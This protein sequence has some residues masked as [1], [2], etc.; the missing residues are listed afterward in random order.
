MIDRYS[1]GAMALSVLL[2]TSAAQAFDDAKYPD[3]K[4]KWHRAVFR[5]LSASNIAVAVIDPF[6]ARMFAKAQ[7]IAAKTDR[8]D[9]RVLAM[10]AAMMSPQCR[11]PA[12]ER[13]EALQEFVTARASA[14]DEKTALKNQLAAATQSFLKS[15]LRKRIKQLEAHDSVRNAQNSLGPQATVEDLVRA[16]LKKGGG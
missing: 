3:L 15:Q 14:V 5:S 1:L 7:G 4:G 11:P 2:M 8:L 9:A 16:C 6:R 10:Y 13:L 12:P